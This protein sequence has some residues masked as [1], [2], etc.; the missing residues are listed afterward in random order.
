MS[1]QR[2]TADDIV[3]D[4]KARQQQH[5]TAGDTERKNSEGLT[6]EQANGWRRNRGLTA[7]PA[8]AAAG[9]NTRSRRS[10]SD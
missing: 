9:R 8:P 7:W 1:R 2:R 10:V 6:P 5:G 3:R 4:M